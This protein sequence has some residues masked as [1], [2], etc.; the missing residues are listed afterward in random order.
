MNGNIMYEI[1]RQRIADRQRATAAAAEA[2]KQ[3]KT[4]RRR[5]ART[6]AAKPAVLP[7][8]PDFAHQLLDGATQDAV[9]AQRPEAGRGRDA[10]T[11]R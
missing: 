2:R 1:T 7:A 10:R 3:A 5:N 11:S 8:I 9:P 6:A 4:A